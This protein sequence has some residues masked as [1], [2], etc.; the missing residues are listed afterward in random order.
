MKNK[1][2]KRII[3]LG[4]N[5]F[6]AKNLIRLLNKKKINYLAFSK[7]NMNLEKINSV[8]ALQK[9][10]KPNDQIVFISAVAPVKDNFM[11]TKNILILNHVVEALKEVTFKQILYISSDAVYED[12]ADIITENTPRTPVSLHG[13]MHLLREKTLTN[14]FD[15]KLCIVRPTLIYGKD[16]P[17]DGYGPNKFLRQTLNSVDISLFGKGEEQRDHVHVKDVVHTIF[18]CLQNNFRGS[19]NVASGKVI[20]FMNIAK[21]CIK[22]NKKVKIKLLSR[23]GPMPHGGYRKFNIRKLKKYVNTEKFT[24]LKDYIKSY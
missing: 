6:V 2:K 19:L 23:S 3:I 17:H 20:S 7:K 14:F 16:D 10:I 8:N 11:L 18:H 4:K 24:K 9:I 5:G 12:D 22:N 13:N 21:E 15:D 1:L